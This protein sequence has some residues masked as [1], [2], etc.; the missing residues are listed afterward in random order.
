MWARFAKVISTNLLVAGFIST[1]A[2]TFVGTLL[3]Q[4][5][6]AWKAPDLRGVLGVIGG[7]LYA[8]GTS[9]RIGTIQ[10]VLVSVLFGMIGTAALFLREAQKQKRLEAARGPSP[11]HQ[12]PALVG[13]LTNDQ[14]DLLLALL[15]GYPRSIPVKL[16]SAKLIRTYAATEIL[17]ESMERLG[18]VTVIPGLHEA[19]SLVLT[20][21]GRNLCVAR[22]FDLIV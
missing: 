11:A 12:P 14:R 16:V 8:P 6:I 22:N 20:E 15:E 1:V 4:G 9:T 19:K 13:A 2:G 21:Q 18:L 7:W 3:V 10:L 17:A 5:Y